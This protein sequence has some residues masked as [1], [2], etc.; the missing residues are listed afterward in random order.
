MKQKARNIVRMDG[1]ADGRMDG[2]ADGRTDGRRN[3]LIE[4]RFGTKML[5]ALHMRA[6]MVI[7]LYKCP[8]FF[9]LQ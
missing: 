6:G 1:R 8:S 2:W 4:M 5:F 3:I 7:F 9:M